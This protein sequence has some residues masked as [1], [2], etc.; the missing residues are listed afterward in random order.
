MKKFFKKTKEKF[1][2]IVSLVVA[3]VL[4]STSVLAVTAV[5]SH[6]VVGC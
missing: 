4:I 2:L 1:P 6:C 5:V 3:S